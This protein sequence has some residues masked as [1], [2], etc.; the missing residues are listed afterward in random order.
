MKTIIDNAYEFL[1][2]RLKYQTEA[3]FNGGQH[4]AYSGKT[5]ELFVDNIITLFKSRY[6]ALDIEVRDDRDKIK[7]M[8][9]DG[10]TYTQ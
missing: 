7:V 10:K 2:N 1:W 3:G 4:R 9:K 5:T 8:G 6:P